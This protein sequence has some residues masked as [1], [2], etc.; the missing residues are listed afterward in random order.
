MGQNYANNILTSIY[1]RRLGLQRMTSS[2][3]GGSGDRELLV[4]PDAF[5]LPNTTG[6]TTATDAKA[7]GISMFSGSSAASS[8]V[9][10]LEPPIPGVEKLLYFPSTG[11]KNCYVKTKNSEVIHSTRGSS[12]TVIQSTIGGILRLVGVTTA[13]WAAPGLSSGT[14]SQN[15][16]FAL[17]TTT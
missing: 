2:I 16:G 6:E 5:R 14:S 9:F 1:G 3:H 8:S 12:F 4:G 7:Y 10:T 15:P 13:I 11:D 17:T